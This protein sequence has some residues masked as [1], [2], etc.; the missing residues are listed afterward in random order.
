[1]KVSNNY[2]ECFIS[3]VKIAFLS[4]GGGASAIPFMKKEYLDNRKWVTED[5][6]SDMVVLS[7]LLPGPTISQ[8][9]MLVSKKKAGY[10]GALAGLFGL[11]FT[12]PIL[13]IIL[14]KFMSTFF[15][16]ENLE[17]L[18][19]AILPVIIFMLV[20]FIFD[21]YKKSIS[22]TGV[23]YNVVVIILSIVLI[24][25]FKIN[26]VIIFLV[27]ILGIIIYTLFMNSKSNHNSNYESSGD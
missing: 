7:N 27:F 6:F 3:G 25:Y 5:E 12:T 22:K 24:G 8:I 20:S 15:S 9:V 19:I 11:L 2:Y 4:F 13:L 18:T 16:K 26:I 21:F 1:M 14:L 10:I 17:K 23:M